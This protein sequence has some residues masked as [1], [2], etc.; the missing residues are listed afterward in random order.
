MT[1]VPWKKSCRWKSSDLF[2]ASGL[3]LTTSVSKVSSRDVDAK[4]KLHYLDIFTD[5]RLKGETR[6]ILEGQPGSGKTMLSSQLAYDWSC[7]KVKD[8]PIVIYLPLKLVEDMTIVQAIKSFYI[9]KNIPILD[10]DIESILANKMIKICLILDGLEEYNGRPKD[11]EPSEVMR[12]MLKEK[13]PNCTVIITA[14]SDYAKDLPPSPMLKIGSFGVDER[15]E[16]IE[17]IFSDDIERQETVKEVIKNVPVIIELCN[18]PLLFVLSVHNID[19]LAR[20]REEQLDRVTPF[21]KAIVDIL[22]PQERSMQER[23]SDS[24]EENESEEHE[25]SVTQSV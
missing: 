25:T 13:L 7:G 3:V 14:R 11:G 24:D 5:E 15:N 1:P 4:C 21:I 9:R 10:E 16:Y 8:V 12:V 23:D 20:L 18:I 19:S 22:C 6:I 2:V 17:K